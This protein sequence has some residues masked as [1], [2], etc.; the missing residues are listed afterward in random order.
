MTT[1][2]IPANVPPV[3][4]I[5]TVDKG[6]IVLCC[7]CGGE[8]VHELRGGPRTQEWRAPACGMTLSSADRSTG[9]TYILPDGRMRGRR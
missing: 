1:K 7:Y 3:P 2:H 9:Y 8:H 6:V 4:V 5:G